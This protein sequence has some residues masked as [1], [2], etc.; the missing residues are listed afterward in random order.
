MASRKRSSKKTKAKS[1]K[2]VARK[3]TKKTTAKTAQKVVR[4]KPTHVRPAKRPAFNPKKDSANDPSWIA[5]VWDDAL[6]LGAHISI[7]GGTHEAPPRGRAIGA[8]AMQMFTKMSNRWADRAC[9][10]DE[11]HA[12]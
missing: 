5:P 6:L 8:S 12:F 4:G 11:R 2:R 7:A 10:D 9:L 3:R 1:G